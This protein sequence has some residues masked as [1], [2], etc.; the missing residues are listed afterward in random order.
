MN[1]GAVSMRDGVTIKL[2]S[3]SAEHAVDCRS[4]LA[5]EDFRHFLRSG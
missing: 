2:V 1:L 5:R 3:A 4:Y